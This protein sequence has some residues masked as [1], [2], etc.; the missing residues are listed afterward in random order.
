VR[1][2]GKENPRAAVQ[3]IRNS[4]KFNAFRAISS[5]KVY[6]PFVFVAK[7]VNGFAYLDALQ[8]RLLPQLQEDSDNFTLQQDGAPPQFH[9]ELRRHLNTTLPQRWIGRRSRCNEGSALIPRPP[10]SP[11]LTKWKFFLWGYGKDNVYVSPLPT[12]L[13]ELRQR[14]VAAVDT[15][16]C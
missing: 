14:I 13:P 8:L 5:R 6:G 9:L 15:N 10:R 16:R 12:D 7:S 2:C 3:H 1:I 11:E 4:P